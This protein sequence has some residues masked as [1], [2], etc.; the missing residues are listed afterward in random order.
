MRLVQPGKNTC[1]MTNFS[2]LLA[3]FVFFAHGMLSRV[4]SKTHPG[5]HENREIKRSHFPQLRSAF[6]ERPGKNG[7]YGRG[8]GAALLL[9]D[10]DK[11][12]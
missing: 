8:S 6:R 3:F 12:L 1:K 4:E 11:L 2:T 10:L 9:E 7:I 5:G